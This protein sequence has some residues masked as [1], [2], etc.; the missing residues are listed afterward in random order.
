MERNNFG[1]SLIEMSVVLLIIST[2]MG[3]VILLTGKSQTKLKYEDT[4][5]KIK[6]IDEALIRYAMRAGEL[7]CPARRNS[8][9]NNTNLGVATDCNAAITTVAAGGT[10]AVADG[11]LEAG[12]VRIGV[13]PTRTLGLPDN[14]MFD[15]WGM[16]ITYAVNRNLAIDDAT[17]QAYTK[18]AVGGILI[19]DSNGNS[20]FDTD[21]NAA[22]K[23]VGVSG[24]T[25]TFPAFIII[26]HGDNKKG[27]TNLSGATTNACTAG[28]MD[29]L[30]CGN[31]GTFR[32]TSI[33]LIN[34]TFAAYFDDIVL[35]RP[36]D[37]V[38]VNNYY[39]NS[40]TP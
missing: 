27:A 7:P 2:I 35:W 16:R 31:T 1:F 6:E 4:I 22:I 38:D 5:A 33:K 34:K 21:N 12:Q 8:A 25:K 11:V 23:P 20:A 14:Y 28:T 40:I 26:S 30:N 17:F 10:G 15:A 36:Y 9:L 19:Q 13:V 3:S 37:Y 32:D 29:V 39:T 24:L 18:P